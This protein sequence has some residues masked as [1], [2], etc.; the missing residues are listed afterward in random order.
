MAFFTT[1]GLSLTPFEISK[2]SITTCQLANAASLYP[3][4]LL[5]RLL[6]QTH[7][8]AIQ[9]HTHH[10]DPSFSAEHISGITIADDTVKVVRQAQAYGD[11]Y[12]DLTT[13]QRRERS[14]HN[15]Y[16]MLG[17][18]FIQGIDMVGFQGR[19]GAK[20]GARSWLEGLQTDAKARKGWVEAAF[21]QER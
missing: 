9:I 12:S 7:I 17:W 2:I 16:R 3:R 18:E 10:A 4:P 11:Y 21:F 14:I 6:T 5:P 1:S 8:S 19:V 20:G 15:N 13:E